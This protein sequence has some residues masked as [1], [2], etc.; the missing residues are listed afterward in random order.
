V[1]KNGRELLDLVL[2]VAVCAEDPL[3]KG[4]EVGSAEKCRSWNRPEEIVVR[5]ED[6]S[7]Q[8]QMATSGGLLRGRRHRRESGQV[9]R[10]SPREAILVNKTGFLEN[11]RHRIAEGWQEQLKAFPFAGTEQ[12]PEGT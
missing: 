6:W 7:Y 8:F 10:K 2:R 3:A 9:A 1:V 4:G 12:K 5:G 11:H